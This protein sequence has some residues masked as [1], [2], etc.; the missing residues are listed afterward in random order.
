M[1]KNQPLLQHT[2]MGPFGPET[3][4]TAH[5]AT[6]SSLH[7]FPLKLKKFSVIQNLWGPVMLKCQAKSFHNYT[8][9]STASVHSVSETTHNQSSHNKKSKSQGL[10][11]EK[12][13]INQLHIIMS[14]V[15]VHSVSDTTLSPHSPGLLMEKSRINQFHSIHSKHSL[16]FRNHIYLD[17]T[18]QRVVACWW[19]KVESINFIVSTVSVHS[20]SETTLI[21][22][23]HFKVVA[24]WWRKVESIHFIIVST[25]SIHSVSETLFWWLRNSPAGLRFTYI[26]SVL[27]KSS[28]VLTIL[29]WWISH[30]L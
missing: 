17:F 8:S 27:T 1:N 18:F 26:P 30:F 11:I 19:R 25:V 24:C 23:S 20:V 3:Q 14:S 4:Q 2:I 12:N 16:S 7:I 10:M 5:G 28:I 13:W 22:S 9:F 21:W 15:N 29:S 6:L